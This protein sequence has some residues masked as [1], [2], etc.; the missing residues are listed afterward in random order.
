MDINIDNILGDSS[1]SDE[2]I[3]SKEISMSIE[4]NYKKFI[5]KQEKK[6]NFMDELYF[7]LKKNNIQKIKFLINNNLDKLDS[8]NLL[9]LFFC[10]FQYN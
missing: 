1:S 7:L 2:E 5:S 3:F 4:N 9:Q 6:V 8:Y 10:C